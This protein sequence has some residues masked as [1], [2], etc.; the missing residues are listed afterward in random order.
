MKKSI[1]KTLLSLGVALLPCLASQAANLLTN[2]G[3]VPSSPGSYLDYTASAPPGWTNLGANNGP[4]ALGLISSLTNGAVSSMQPYNSNAFMYDLG[5]L[6]NP[7]PNVGDGITQTFATRPGHRYRLSFG[8]N[9]E[10]AGSALFETGTDALRVQ[11]GG[12][13]GAGQTFA[14]PFDR[15]TTGYGLACCAWQGA[16][17]QRI[18]D[19]TASAASTSVAFTVASVSTNSY[20]N[21]SVAR[22]GSNSQIIAWPIIEEIIDAPT[23]T[24]TK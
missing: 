1:L 11:V 23:I 7:N 6:V 16:W 15:T 12:V 20:G 10:A 17:A 9:A 24:L 18:L 8:H 21:A 4:M 13:G 22:T 5:G 14:S 3:F 2:P 19:F